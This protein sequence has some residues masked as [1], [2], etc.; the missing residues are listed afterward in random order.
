MTADISQPSKKKFTL[1]RERFLSESFRD[2]GSK[3]ILFSWHLKVYGSIG[4]P[5]NDRS[6]HTAHC[7]HIYREAARS[8]Q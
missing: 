3:K 7:T 8:I 1:F 2:S 6:L 5:R 4:I